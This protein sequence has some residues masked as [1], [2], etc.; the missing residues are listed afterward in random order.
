MFLP[1][2]FSLEVN[3]EAAKWFRKIDS[4]TPKDFIIPGVFALVVL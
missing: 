2:V 1:N 4:E 3:T